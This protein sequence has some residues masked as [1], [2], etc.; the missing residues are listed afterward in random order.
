MTLNGYNRKMIAFAT[1]RIK[2]S[3]KFLIYVRKKSADRTL[4][5]LSDLRTFEA[6]K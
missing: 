6:R 4:N 1:H 5:S 2:T 3:E